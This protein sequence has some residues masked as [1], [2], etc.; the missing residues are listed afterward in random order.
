MITVLKM[1]L[2]LKCWATY[3]CRDARVVGGKSVRLSVSHLLGLLC[4]S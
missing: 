4:T 1:G 3:W 2:N